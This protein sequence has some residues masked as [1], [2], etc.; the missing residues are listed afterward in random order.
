M[1]STTLG[2]F[3]IFLSGLGTGT[4]AWPM[5]RIQVMQFEHYWFIGM[6]TGLVIIPWAVVMLF[7]PDALQAFAE[8][9]VKTLLVAN[10]LSLG[11]G[12]ANVL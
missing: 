9:G 10:L 1:M 11:W 6:L 8:V 3:L 5:K 2:I 4:I 7:I 12:I